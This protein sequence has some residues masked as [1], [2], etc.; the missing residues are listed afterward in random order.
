MYVFKMVNITES[1][2]SPAWDAPHGMPRM[3]AGVE[4]IGI[5]SRRLGVSY[6]SHF[7]KLIR[8]Y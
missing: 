6:I 4:P 5:Y 3:D 2:A 1:Q 8:A 7:S